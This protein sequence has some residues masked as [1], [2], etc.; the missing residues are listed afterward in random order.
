MKTTV[1]YLDPSHFTDDKS[2][3]CCW[4]DDYDEFKKEI[5]E[6]PGVEELTLGEFQNLFNGCYLSCQGIIIFEQTD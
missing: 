2:Q 5:K 6:A 3:A 1:Y 4:A